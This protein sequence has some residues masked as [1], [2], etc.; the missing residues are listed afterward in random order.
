VGGQYPLIKMVPFD[1]LL[2]LLSEPDCVSLEAELKLAEL[3]L[4]ELEEPEKLPELDRPV[5][6][7]RLPE[8][9]KLPGPDDETLLRLD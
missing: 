4:T 3:M 2:E 6:E 7:E 8:L 9:D 5:E 1:E